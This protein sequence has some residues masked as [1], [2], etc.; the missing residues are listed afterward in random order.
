MLYIISK[1]LFFLQDSN[2]KLNDI[3]QIFTIT[4]IRF[5][6]QYSKHLKMGECQKVASHIV[7]MYLYRK[8][9]PDLGRDEQTV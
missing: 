7:H 1:W 5:N 9:A 8:S 4:Y 2:G 3:I 6:F